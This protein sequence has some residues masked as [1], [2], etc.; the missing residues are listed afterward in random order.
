MA[1]TEARPTEYKGVR[2]RSKCEAMFARYLDLEREE[3]VRCGFGPGGFEYEPSYLDVDGWKPDFLKWFVIDQVVVGN[4]CGPGIRYVVIEYKPSRPTG[5]YI[6]EFVERV[7]KL[8][9]RLL[10]SGCLFA[11]EIEAAIYFGSVFNTDRDCF[12]WIPD[13]PHRDLCG[14]DLTDPDR[15]KFDWLINFED[16][17]KETRFDLA[18]S[19]M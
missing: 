3:S 10:S 9:H 13:G 1:I 4:F 7:T 17:V 5:T 11:L 6:E 2:Y 18:E 8:R 14:D 12:H 15:D 19:S 16:D